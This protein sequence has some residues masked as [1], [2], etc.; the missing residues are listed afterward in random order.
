MDTKETAPEF[1][2]FGKARSLGCAYTWAIGKRS[3]GKTYDAK[4]ICVDKYK[5]D[6]SSFVIM[7]RYHSDIT[8][9]KM[10]D[11]FSDIS[12]YTEDKIDDFVKYSTERHFY[13]DIDGEFKTIGYAI[14]IEDMYR[15]KGRNFP[16]VKTIVFDEVIEDRYLEDEIKYFLNTISTIVRNRKDVE[17][18]MTANTIS[19][20]CPYFDLF[21]IDIQKLKKGSIHKIVMKSGVSIAVHYCKDSSGVGKEE[22]HKYLGFDENGSSDMI[23]YGE[24]EYDEY[25]THSIDGIGW[26]CKNRRL[27]FAYVTGIGEVYEMSLLMNE[28]PIA[29]IRNVNIRDGKCNSTIKYNFSMDKSIILTNKKGIIPMY[30]KINKFVD[31]DTKTRIECLRECIKAGRAVYDTPK[32]GTEFNLCFEK[33]I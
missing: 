9:N 24:W 15:N 31:T 13:I 20:Y 6:G 26:N 21:G 1:Y 33:I 12:E 32:T 16:K 23:L 10:A 2:S 27:I 3:N 22:S 29:F 11:F 30:R 7:R 18:L 25:E 5:N 4:K 17:I 14:A 19:R 8:R 28:N